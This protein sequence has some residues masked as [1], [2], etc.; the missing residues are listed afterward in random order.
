M[1]WW[2]GP[3]VTAAII[4]GYEGE[5]NIFRRPVKNIAAPGREGSKFP[6]WM[7]FPGEDGAISSLP[8]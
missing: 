6:V 3:Q 1:A 8:G 4:R 5:V 7:L 2:P